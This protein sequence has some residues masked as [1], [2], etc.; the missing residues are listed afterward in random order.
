MANTND[1]QASNG[2][3][4]R[5]SS[6]VRL[7]RRAERRIRRRSKRERSELLWRWSEVLGDEN[8]GRDR[9]SVPVCVVDLVT[10]MVEV[11][12]CSVR[13]YCSELCS[14]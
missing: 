3:T 6:G 7:R 4:D 11:V 1:E 9:R 2:R 5:R 12:A 8:A 10:Q 13:I 14:L